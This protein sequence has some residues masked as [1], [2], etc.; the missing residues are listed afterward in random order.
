MERYASI[1]C[2]QSSTKGKRLTIDGIAYVNRLLLHE[3]KFTLLL[4]LVY[5]LMHSWWEQILNKQGMQIT[6]LS[7]NTR[8]T[9]AGLF[10]VLINLCI[11]SN[12]LEI[13]TNPDP[14]RTHQVAQ[15]V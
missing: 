1:K 5:F 13:E 2:W 14:I 7:W 4:K 8:K 6:C 12:I 9:T 10:N 15:V 11:L 3:I